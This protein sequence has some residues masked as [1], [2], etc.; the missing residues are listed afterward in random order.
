VIDFLIGFLVGG[1]RSDRAETDL[2][3]RERFRAMI[4]LSGLASLIGAIVIATL[5]I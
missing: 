3:R 4:V 5:L 2:E 1:G